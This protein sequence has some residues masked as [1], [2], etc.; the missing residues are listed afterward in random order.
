MCDQ[1][2]G[3]TARTWPFSSSHHT[4]K[5]LTLRL[6]KPCCVFWTIPLERNSLLRMNDVTT[7]D[8]FGSPSPSLCTVDDCPIP[9]ALTIDSPEPPGNARQRK[10][11]IPRIETIWAAL[12]ILQEAQISLMD[13]VFFLFSVVRTL[14]SVPIVVPSWVLHESLNSWTLSGTPRNSA[15]LSKPGLKVLE[16]H[17]FAKW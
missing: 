5:E 2:T 14:I 16:P 3:C 4:L 8:A 13:L 15:R 17:M 6:L 11:R 10:A 1:H 9:R 12:Q 7:I